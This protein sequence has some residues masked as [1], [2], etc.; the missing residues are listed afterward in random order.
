[1]V[2]DPV[3]HRESTVV[4]SGT[5]ASSQTTLQEEMLVHVSVI[6]KVMLLTSNTK[7]KVTRKF[8][9]EIVQLFF[10]HSSFT[11]QHPLEFT[12]LIFSVKYSLK[13]LL[14]GSIPTVLYEDY[15]GINLD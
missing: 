4:S 14:D 3:Q 1:M 11:K 8:N 7:S 5:K 12:L 10:S 9:Q 13:L 2:A 6:D 15:F